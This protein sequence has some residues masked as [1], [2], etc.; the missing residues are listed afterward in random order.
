MLGL[1]GCA[2][3]R[4]MTPDHLHLL[5]RPIT[6]TVLAYG[7]EPLQFGELTL[8]KGAG[9]HP[10]LI[11]LHG[12]CWLAPYTISHSRA[13]AQAMADEGYAVWSVEYR[14]IGDAGGGWPNTFLDVARAAYHVRALADRYPLDSSRIVVGGH[15]A[16]GQLA[17]WLAAR[18]K[19]DRHGELWTPS[20]V[21]PS[22]VLALAPAAGLTALEAKGACDHVIDKLVGGS[23]E[24]VPERF[25][26]VEPAR[27][28]PIGVAQTL[29]LGR[30]DN[31]WTWLG[32]AYAAQARSA[33]D[34][35]IRVIE[36]P[37]A[38]HFEMIAPASTTWPLVVQAAR[39]LKP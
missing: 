7:A 17:L 35:H 33:G 6:G 26:A 11:W 24:E 3:P 30:Y 14:S 12:G 4:L 36:A 15:S 38:A 16:G 21:I 37:H 1:V 5:E 2:A 28:A 20:P 25:A 31:D 29:I 34:T 9:P 23:P 39:A 8:P 10:V 32:E 19:I 27:L 22:A 18:G 13:F